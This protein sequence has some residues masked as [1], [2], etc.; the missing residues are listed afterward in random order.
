MRSKD[1]QKQ[2]AR[3]SLNIPEMIPLMLFLDMLPSSFADNFITRVNVP[4]AFPPKFKGKS[5]GNEVDA[6]CVDVFVNDE[7]AR[8]A[9]E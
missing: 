7:K 3:T 8:K 4:R 9:R 2:L 6:R 5:P 1:A